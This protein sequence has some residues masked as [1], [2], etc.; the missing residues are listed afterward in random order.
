MPQCLC[1]LKEEWRAGG[2]GMTGQ[3]YAD[4]VTKHAVAAVQK[5]YGTPAV[6]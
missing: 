2:G 6:W 3:V 5:L 4:M 1:D